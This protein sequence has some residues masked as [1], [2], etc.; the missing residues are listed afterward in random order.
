ML[1]SLA[2]TIL[3]GLLFGMQADMDCGDFLTQPTAQAYFE[4]GGGSPTNNFD[5]MDVDGDGIACETLPRTTTE[6]AAPPASVEDS[7][8]S[9]RW[10]QMDVLA[11]IMASAVVVIG[12][13]ASIWALIRR[14][15]EAHKNAK[16]PTGTPA[17]EVTVTPKA[18]TAV[19]PASPK[20][21]PA[22][23]PAFPKVALASPLPPTVAVPGSPPIPSVSSGS[24][25]K[26]LPATQYQNYLH[27]AQWKKKR[28]EVFAQFGQHCAVCPETEG[29]E[30]H[31][32]TYDRLGYEDVND[33]TV[34]CRKHHAMYY[35]KPE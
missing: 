23:P 14:W 13:L 18:V 28:A 9:S 17:S 24:V 34:L 1:L 4:Q 31:H 16:S 29:L 3:L 27:S 26:R 25:P 7:D 21:A 10:S 20:A 6:V 33:L 5:N 19:P 15:R 2:G 8:S 35:N 22:A 12:G 30:V 11:S 32:R